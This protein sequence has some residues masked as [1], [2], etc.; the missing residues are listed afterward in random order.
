MQHM[1]YENQ[2][3][4]ENFIKCF[5]RYYALLPAFVA[6]S[7]VQE[8]TQEE[9]ALGQQLITVLDKFSVR[10]DLRLKNFPQSLDSLTPHVLMANSLLR[11]YGQLVNLKLARVVA[12]NEPS[13]FMYRRTK[14]RACSCVVKDQPATVVEVK[15]NCLK[16]FKNQ[17][18]YSTKLGNSLYYDVF[19][20]FEDTH[21]A[22]CNCKYTVVETKFARCQKTQIV[23]LTH[24]QTRGV[25]DL[26]RQT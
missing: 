5:F 3:L 1:V 12:V 4:G 16:V 24:C 20:D 18:N 11:E 26:Q 6:E 7:F 8:L 14:T 22:L 2:F 9:P 25:V 13:Q 19:D 23:S 15:Q 10:I 21:C 17:V